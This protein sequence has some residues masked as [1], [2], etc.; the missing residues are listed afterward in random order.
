MFQ[1]DNQQEYMSKAL[2]IYTEVYDK[3]FKHIKGINNGIEKPW[4]IAKHRG[5]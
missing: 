3:L 2:S 1:Y 5:L 4:Y